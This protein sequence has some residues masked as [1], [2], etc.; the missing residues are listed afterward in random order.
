MSALSFS[1]F[2][3]FRVDPQQF[4]HTVMTILEQIMP[5]SENDQLR[6]LREQGFS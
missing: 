6:N 4:T 3:A 1:M 2:N 5:G